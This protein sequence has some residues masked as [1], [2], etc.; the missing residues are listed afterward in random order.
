MKTARLFLCLVA[1][2]GIPL[3]EN[4]ADADELVRFESVPV[5]LSPFRIRKAG[6]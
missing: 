6:E 3:A 1:C 5:K 2:L 4:Q